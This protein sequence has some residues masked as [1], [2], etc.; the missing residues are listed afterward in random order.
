MKTLIILLVTILLSSCA[1]IFNGTTQAVPVSSSPSGAEIYVNNIFRGITP[2][3]LILN[4]NEP[5]HIINVALAEYQPHQYTLTRTI[6]PL[7][8]GNLFIG[9]IPGLL[10]DF[11][12][13]GAYDL[14]PVEINA[15]LIRY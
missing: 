14:S 6:S 15:M 13:G 2:E 3:V 9:G 10:I 1:T 5:T 7:V 8:V 4:R 11:I 12:S